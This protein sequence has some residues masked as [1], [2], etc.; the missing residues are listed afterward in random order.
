MLSYLVRAARKSLE[1]ATDI[2]TLRM[3]RAKRRG[4][5]TRFRQAA[6]WRPAPLRVAL[7]CAVRI[8]ARSFMMLTS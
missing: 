1:A 8:S 5:L 6:M 4:S 7:S 3:Q 2:Y